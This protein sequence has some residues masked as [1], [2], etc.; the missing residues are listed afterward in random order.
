MSEFD[1]MNKIVEDFFDEIIHEEPWWKQFELVKLPSVPAVGNIYR[2]EK[3]V[4]LNI[5]DY[6]KIIKTL[7]EA[8]SAVSVYEDIEHYLSE[9]DR[10]LIMASEEV[11]SLRKKN[12]TLKA[13]KKQYD[14]I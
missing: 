10:R 7:Q 3:C 1:T 6:N 8:K 14:E 5:G 4:V 13:K 9:I 2:N 11:E 12:K